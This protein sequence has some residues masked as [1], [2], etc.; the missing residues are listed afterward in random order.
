[1][2]VFY[3]LRVYFADGAT[4]IACSLFQCCFYLI[5]SYLFVVSYLF[6]CFFVLF[7]TCINSIIDENIKKIINECL[8]FSGD[9]M[10]SISVSKMAL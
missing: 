5:A 8:L 2:N 9:K 3:N 10:F 1:V 6:C 4:V 7:I